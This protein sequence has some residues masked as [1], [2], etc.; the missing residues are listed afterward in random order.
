MV[1]L[2]VMAVLLAI[3][4]P[5]MNDLVQA[6][7]QQAALTRLSSAMRMGQYEA[8]RRNVRVT[9]CPA[10]P[11]R[12]GCR[13]AT[14]G[15]GPHAALQDW[16]GELMAFIDGGKPREMDGGDR[17]LRVFPA[18]RGVDVF[19]WYPA[20][21]QG[22]DSAGYALHLLPTGLVCWPTSR[23]QVWVPA[24]YPCRTNVAFTAC[25]RTARHLPARHTAMTRGGLHEMTSHERM[26]TAYD[27][28]SSVNCSSNR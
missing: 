21:G 26:Q 1:V 15:S 5:S 3:A 12:S 14:I 10:Q 6:S 16:S 28:Q 22:M 20:N 19:A 24:D 25:A 7:Q 17:L 4:A 23:R 9:V 8:N 27:A 18:A 13:D 11:D 2:S